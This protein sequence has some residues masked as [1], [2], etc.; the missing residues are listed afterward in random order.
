M[1]IR[2]DI[3]C[4]NETMTSVSDPP[5]Q[6]SPKHIFNVL[7][8]DCI[9]EIFK[10]FDNIKD[11]LNAAEVC[12][13]FQESAKH[14]FPPINKLTYKDSG[15]YCQL[16]M[17]KNHWTKSQLQLP[18]SRIPRFLSIF[19]RFIENIVWSRFI[20][21]CGYS[22]SKKRKIRK[23]DEDELRM[24]ANSCG[25]NVKELK[26]GNRYIDLKILQKFKALE[27][28]EI[29]LCRRIYYVA[30]PRSGPFSSLK[31][32]KLYKFAGDNCDWL[33]QT[34]PK[35]IAVNLRVD[36]RCKKTINQFREL[37]PQLEHPIIEFRNFKTDINIYRREYFN[38]PLFFAC[39]FLN[40]QLSFAFCISFPIGVLLILIYFGKLKLWTSS[41]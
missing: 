28:L 24:F 38:Y 2:I 17:W 41:V 1:D 20:I 9:R 6:T 10:Y 3:D 29:S 14:C 4:E 21:I 31:S 15:E 22:S 18:Y 19:G 33:K 34:F 36:V 5:D 12:T 37:N 11:F 23:I 8:N 25:K 30:E 13:R 35:L 27:K 40:V 16:E 39:F 7:N 32:L 26:I